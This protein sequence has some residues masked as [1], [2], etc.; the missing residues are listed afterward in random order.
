MEK[1][2]I[3]KLP[4]LGG[5]YLFKNKNG[6]IIYIGKAKSIRKRIKD[7]FTQSNRVAKEE[8][9]TGQTEV[10]EFI[11]TA[12]E[13]EALL[14]ESYLI[15][16][17]RPRYNISLRDDKSYP[18]VK[19]TLK[20][21]FPRVIITRVKSDDG[22]LYLGPYPDVKELRC[23]LKVLRSVF[24]FRS[25]RAFP[26]SA[27][28][29]FHIDLCSAPCVKRIDEHEYRKNII[30][31]IKSLLGDVDGVVKDLTYDM[32]IYVREKEFENAALIRDKLKSLGKVSV[33]SG[34]YK[35]INA[36][37]N[38]KQKLGLPNLPRVIDG[39][40]I[41]NISGSTATGSVVR[42]KDGV[43]LKI[44]YRR[45]KIKKQNFI[46][47]YAMMV[48][49]VTRRYRGVGKKE[50]PDLI[51]LDGGRG[52][53]N[54]IDKAL[55]DHLNLNLSLI[56]Y[57]K[58]KNV[59]HS[60]YKKRES[61]FP[62]SSAEINLLARIRDEAHRFAIGYHKYLRSKKMQES[63]LEGIPGVGKEKIKLILR[64]WGET[65]D[66]KNISCDDFKKIEGIGEILAERISEYVKQKK[67]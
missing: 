10:I 36:L 45:F 55:K 4:D 54:K 28:L 18:Y 6:S 33:L 42:F 35:S 30:A 29:Y 39:V 38:I 31:I 17:K 22:S 63:G 16:E 21:D 9:I 61:I 13:S 67:G 65:R 59:I 15:K 47:D 43:P 64:Q 19:I 26:K 56:A 12:S 44:F 27:C 41:S 5:V 20:E 53:L 3:N 25:C 60:K 66:S 14:L 7:H 32:D 48:E 11:I 52:H 49:V 24:P 34:G 40:D 58:G 50:I 8:N 57:A 37:E 62:A 46:N 23:S 2:K 51:V 1:S